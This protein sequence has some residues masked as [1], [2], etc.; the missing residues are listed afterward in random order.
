[1]LLVIKLLLPAFIQYSQAQ[2]LLCEFL[3]RNLYAFRPQIK[4]NQTPVLD[5]ANTWQGNWFLLW[6]DQ[7]MSV[8]ITFRIL[9]W[10]FYFSVLFF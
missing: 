10:L 7:I 9:M 8:I 4:W 2:F 5:M 1:M 6:G 3:S